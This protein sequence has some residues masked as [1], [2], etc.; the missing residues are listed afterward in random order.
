MLSS[1]QLPQRRSVQQLHKSQWL[2]VLGTVGGCRGSQEGLG[3]AT[4]QGTQRF[5]IESLGCPFLE[6]RPLCP[7]G[8]GS[9][10]VLD[11]FHEPIRPIVY[12]VHR[13]LLCGFHEAQGYHLQEVSSLRM[14]T[15]ICRVFGSTPSTGFRLFHRLAEMR[16][17]TSW[18]VASF[19]VASLISFSA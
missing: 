1:H 14:L 7:T 19:L 10:L 3:V 8:Y 12:E 11:G 6:A 2:L 17:L 16:R 5:T 15:N 13:A 9:L 18:R 4:W